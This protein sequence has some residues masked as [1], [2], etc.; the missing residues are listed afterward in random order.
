VTADFLVAGTASIDTIARR[1]PYRPAEEVADRFGELIALGLVEERD[2]A[3]AATGTFLP[4]LNAARACVA[5]IASGLWSGHERE[6]EVVSGLARRVAST[7][8]DD[9]VVAVVHRELPAADDPYLLAYD[10]LVTLRYIRQHAH[11]VAWQERDLAAPM[12]VAM[13]ALWYE[14]E[15]DGDHA[16][17][18]QL[19]ERGLAHSGPARLTESGK[20]LRDEI[21]TETNRRAQQSFDVLSQAEADTLLADLR[22]LPG[23]G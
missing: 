19:V 17:L 3:L 15:V 14:E 16:G 6:V 23:S 1:M 21:E 18:A 9:H 22:S 2:D 7:A 4:L 8:S 12:M 5:D 11:V 13:T 20:E 10:R